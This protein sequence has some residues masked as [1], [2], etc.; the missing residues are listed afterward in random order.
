MLK[1]AEGPFFFFREF[2]RLWEPARLRISVS[3]GAADEQGTRRK[4]TL[5]WQ[6]AYSCLGSRAKWSLLPRHRVHARKKERAV[7]RAFSASA[8]RHIY[9]DLLR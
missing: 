6:I 8:L 2:V 4:L 9:K 3:P 7:A 5:E 1:V